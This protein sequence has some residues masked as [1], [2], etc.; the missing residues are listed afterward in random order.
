MAF[1]GVVLRLSKELSGLPELEALLLQDARVTLGPSAAERQALTL[2]GP[3]HELTEWLER[4]MDWPGVLL[5]SPVFHSIE[6]ELER[7][8]AAHPESEA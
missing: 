8:E 7:V 4:A 2:E 1:I 6:D 5:V 3:T